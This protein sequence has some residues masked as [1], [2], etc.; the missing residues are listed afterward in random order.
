MNPERLLQKAALLERRAKT[1]YL[2]SPGDYTQTIRDL[3]ARAIALRQ[4]AEPKRRGFYG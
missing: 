4:K 2:L 3:N 1:L